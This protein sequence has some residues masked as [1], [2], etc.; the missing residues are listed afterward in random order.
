L[1]DER[2]FVTR[3]EFDNDDFNE[4]S[5]SDVRAATALIF[6]SD[7]IPSSLDNKFVLLSKILVGDSEGVSKSDLTTGELERECQS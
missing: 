7:M 2:E 4:K 1:L 6:G 5:D 3:S